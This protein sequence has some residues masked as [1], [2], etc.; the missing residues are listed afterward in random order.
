MTNQNKYSRLLH[1]A[2]IFCFLLP[3][4]YN[5]CNMVSAADKKKA[6]DKRIQ[7]S[8]ENV[9]R[10]IDSLNALKS[11]ADF[12]KSDT[13]QNDTIKKQILKVISDTADKKSQYLSEEVAKE[14]KFLKPILIPNENIHTGLATVIDTFP[15]ITNF[16]I[17]IS[18]LLLII[19]L[20]IK[21]IDVNSK[22]SIGL[23][24]ILS[25]I[26]LSITQ[27]GFFT[28]QTLWGF[29]VCLTVLILLTIY[30]LY[31]IWLEKH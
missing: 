22:K 6:E 19:S 9:C 30:D 18:L 15:Y 20:T 4:F 13:A 8:I 1:I 2:T 29:G 12:I 5:G 16:S 24:D 31:L 21:F 7:D 10:S 25:L 11:Y 3:F 28:S 26:F 17:F 23:L 14:Y 27:S